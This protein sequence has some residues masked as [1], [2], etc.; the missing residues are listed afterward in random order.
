MDAGRQ[1]P[2]I[3]CLADKGLYKDLTQKR[4]VTVIL[5]ELLGSTC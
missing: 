1:K 2:D 4:I 5:S 3:H